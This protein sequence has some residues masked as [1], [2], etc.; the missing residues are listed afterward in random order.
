M[1][2]KVGMVDVDLGRF[3]V[4]AAKLCDKAGR[5]ELSP[6]V[7]TIARDQWRALGREDL[8]SEAQSHL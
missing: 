4:E 2:T 8:E 7:W 1:V 5:T 3:A 6:R